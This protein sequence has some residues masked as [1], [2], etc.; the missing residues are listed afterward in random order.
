M[1][2]LG[3]GESV[4]HLANTRLASAYSAYVVIV[5]VSETRQGAA[6]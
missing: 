3:T 6:W 4:F 2:Y 5:T 1:H